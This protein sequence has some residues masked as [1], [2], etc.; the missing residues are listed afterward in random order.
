MLLKSERDWNI[1]QVWL[2]RF[3]N[4]FL[5]IFRHMLDIWRLVGPVKLEPISKTI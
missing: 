2:I 3:L 5:N 1:R 4:G